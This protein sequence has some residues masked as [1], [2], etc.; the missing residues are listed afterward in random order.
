[1]GCWQPSCGLT[2]VPIHQDQKCVMVIVQDEDRWDSYYDWLPRRTEAI[3]KGTYNDYGWLNEIPKDESIGPDVPILFHEEAWNKVL[4]F[5]FSVWRQEC[6]KNYLDPEQYIEIRMHRLALLE[7][8]IATN[9]EIDK[10]NKKNDKIIKKMFPGFWV[11]HYEEFVKVVMFASAARINI[12]ESRR[13]CG[14]Q[15]SES[16]YREFAMEL[17]REEHE[18]LDR[19]YEET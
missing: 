19:L 1:M 10:Q 17:M 5:E 3:Y 11:D 13:W 15:D 9:E 14:A 18:R 12:F 6:M 4:D 7:S 8:S 16:D 2:N